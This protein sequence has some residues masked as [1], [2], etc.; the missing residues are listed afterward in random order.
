M[1]SSWLWRYSAVC[2]L[3]AAL[4]IPAVFSQWS[5]TLGWGGAG[6]GGKRGA[7]TNS[8]SESDCFGVDVSVIK[9][10]WKL[11]Q[12]EAQRMNKCPQ[13]EVFSKFKH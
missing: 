8:N 10:I 9:Q 11:I 7:P 4:T 12:I 3:I 6:A 1:M 5:Q 13:N 2:L